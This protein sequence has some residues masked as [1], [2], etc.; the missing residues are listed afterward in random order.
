M[1]YDIRSVTNTVLPC[2]WAWVLRSS[3]LWHAISI[4]LT[5]LAVYFHG[6]L[7]DRAW[8]QIEAVFAR[9][10]DGDVDLVHTP[11]WRPI[12]E[13]RDQARF[14]RE[15]WFEEGFATEGT[16]SNSEDN[17]GGL[18]DLDPVLIAGDASD[19]GAAS[20]SK[21]LPVDLG[22]SLGVENVGMDLT[23]P[24]LQLD[25]QN[26]FFDFFVLS[27]DQFGNRADS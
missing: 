23:M 19:F 4:T 15:T 26:D 27:S 3:I 8:A 10:S 16:T 20:N 14:K 9:F 13:L 22:S 25:A 1:E 6:P 18:P 24:D 21:P 5:N 17:R 12:N 7:V 11:I 2:S